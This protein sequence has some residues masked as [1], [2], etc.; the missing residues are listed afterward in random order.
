MSSGVKGDGTEGS[1]IDGSDGGSALN[2]ASKSLR[3]AAKTPGGMLSVGEKTMPTFLP[4]ILLIVEFWIILIK[5]AERV[6]MRIQLGSGSLWTSILKPATL[7]LLSS[8]SV[9]LLAKFYRTRKAFSLPITRRNSR[10]SSRVR[11]VLGSS[12]RYILSKDATAWTS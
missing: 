5:N 12:R 6:L 1:M 3:N 2:I 11:T 7:L 8:F 10:C 4:L 9:N